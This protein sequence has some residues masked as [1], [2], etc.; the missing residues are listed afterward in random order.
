MST[1]QLTALPLPV[2]TAVI[3]PPT[4]L[5]FTALQVTPCNADINM[6]L[7]ESLRSDQRIKLQLPTAGCKEM[8]LDKYMRLHQPGL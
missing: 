2:P 7:L 3:A 6:A 1:N 5:D 4:A 8:M